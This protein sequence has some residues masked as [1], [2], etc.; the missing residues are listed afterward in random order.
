MTLDEASQVLQLIEDAMTAAIDTDGVFL[1]PVPLDVGIIAIRVGL[2]NSKVT[3]ALMADHGWKP[4]Q[5]FVDAR[6][7]KDSDVLDQLIE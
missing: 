3:V 5:D 4:M 2:P 7:S 1:P 6:R